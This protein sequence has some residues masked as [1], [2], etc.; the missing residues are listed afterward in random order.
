MKI[1]ALLLA[2]VSLAADASGVFATATAPNGRQV[3]LY[4]EECPKGTP[5]T[6]KVDL[7]APD[8][9]RLFSGCWYSTGTMVEVT[10][11]DND[12]STIPIRF[13]TLGSGRKQVPQS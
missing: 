6:F 7:M 3:I 2:L 10:W 9:S 4:D 5:Q 11:E 12:Q 8:G 13:F 1:A